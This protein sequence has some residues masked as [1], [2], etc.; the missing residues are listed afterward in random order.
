MEDKRQLTWKCIDCNNELR[1]L[2][3]FNAI[4]VYKLGDHLQL[5]CEGK[6]KKHN[7]HEIVKIN[8]IE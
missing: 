6:C 3:D 2:A 5:I 4:G 8:K 1:V 7:R